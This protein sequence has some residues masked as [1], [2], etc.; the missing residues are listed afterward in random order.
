MQNIS[1]E[2]IEEDTFHLNRIH[3]VLPGSSPDSQCAMENWD[4]QGWRIIN[5]FSLLLPTCE[6]HPPPLLAFN[7]QR[8]DPDVS[9]FLGKP[10]AATDT[11]PLHRLHREFPSCIK[12]S[13]EDKCQGREQ[14]SCPALRHWIISFRDSYR[15][16]F[17]LVNFLFPDTHSFCLLLLS[18]HLHAL[19]HDK[20]FHLMHIWFPCLP[21]RKR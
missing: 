7:G 4:T 9:I 17:G 14:K 2:V 6:P 20:W 16:C 15:C 21:T 1:R 19:I 11:S 13:V 8:E 3:R 5:G 12:I 10:G 18:R